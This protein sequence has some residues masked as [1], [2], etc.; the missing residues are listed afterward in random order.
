MNIDANTEVKTLNEMFQLARQAA[1]QG[2]SP[3]AAAVAVGESVLSRASN[4]TVRKGSPL[5]HAE[6]EALDQ[7]FRK[8]DG[9]LTEATLITTCAPCLMCFATTCYSGIRRIVFSIDVRDVIELGSGD[10]PIEPVELNESFN[11]GFDLIGGVERE[12]G[13][14]LVKDVHNARGWL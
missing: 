14:A 8:V 7:A 1:E 9:E 4:G 2:G 11:L 5:R 3:F 13:L 10:I 6:V 12:R